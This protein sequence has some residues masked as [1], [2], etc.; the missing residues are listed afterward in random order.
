M[1]TSSYDRAALASAATP[2]GQRIPGPPSGGY[3][4]VLILWLLAAAALVAV[5]GPVLFGILQAVA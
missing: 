4:V 2:P 3:L 1:N 5:G